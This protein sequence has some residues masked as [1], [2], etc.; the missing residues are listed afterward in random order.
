MV[1][2]IVIGAHYGSRDW[3]VQRITSVIMIFYVLLLISVI[4]ISAPHD[5][6]AWK[7]IFGNQWIRITS[8]LFFLSLCWHAWIGMRNI[9]MDYVHKTSI[10]L[11]TQ[12]LIILSL[13]FYIVLFFETL[14]S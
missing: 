12:I 13:L 10:R 9:L 8:L 7:K 1:K 11:T 6:V 2:R 5:Y 4:L 14:W 3:L